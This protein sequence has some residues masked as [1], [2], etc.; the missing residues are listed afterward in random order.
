MR[1]LRRL[2]N[3]SYRDR[4]TNIEVRNRVTKEIGPHSELLAMVITKLRWFGHV[5]RSNS[6]S[7]TILQGSIEGIR[8][9]GRP[10]MQWQDNIVKWTGLDINKAM[11]T[12]ENR[13]GWKKIVM[14]STAPLRH[15][16]A[17]GYVKGKKVKVSYKE[18]FLIFFLY[19]F[20]IKRFF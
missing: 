13:E 12:A 16:N 3:I 5:I 19:D 20:L 14:K 6:M 7:K 15:P 18:V 17:M 4:I 8:R 2:L 9:R 1:C 10:K 11:R